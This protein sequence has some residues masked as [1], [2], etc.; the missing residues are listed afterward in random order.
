MYKCIYHRLSFY[1]MIFSKVYLKVLRMI[2][3]MVQTLQVVAI[4]G[5]CNYIDSYKLNFFVVLPLFTSS[6]L[7]LIYL[8][9]L[10]YLFWDHLYLCSSVHQ[11]ICQ[12]SHLTLNWK[13]LLFVLQSVCSFVYL[14]DGLVVLFGFDFTWYWCRYPLDGRRSIS[15]INIWWNNSE[16]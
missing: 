12:Y 7:S 6:W 11:R 14:A 8:H 4:S 5:E 15:S 13:Y 3:S 1:F 10:W 16:P 9:R 2:Q